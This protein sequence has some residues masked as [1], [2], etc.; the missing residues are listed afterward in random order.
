MGDGEFGSTYAGGKV[1]IE[2]HYFPIEVQN[3]GEISKDLA[4]NL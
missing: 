4:S 2:R 1:R 3:I